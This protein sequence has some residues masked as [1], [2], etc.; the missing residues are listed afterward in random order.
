MFLASIDAGKTCGRQFNYATRIIGGE[1][2]D[3]IDEFPWSVSIQ[4]R[5][6]GQ[7]WQECGGSILTDRLVISAA[8]CANNGYVPYRAVFGCAN[9]TSEDCQV[10]YFSYEDWILHP[11][12]KTEDGVKKEIGDIALIKL[13]IKA[14]YSLET[15]KTV[16]SVCLPKRVRDYDGQEVT[17]IGYGLTHSPEDKDREEY[18]DVL[19][20]YTA[21]VI[22][23]SS[24][25]KS[26]VPPLDVNFP[27]EYHL[28][29]SRGSNNEGACNGDS[30]GPL[31]IR[32]RSGQMVVIGL[33]IDTAPD[34]VSGPILYTRVDYYLDWIIDIFRKGF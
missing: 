29:T 8:H 22:D 24:C 6:S 10:I 13:P 9:L 21:K 18:S 26:V 1:D 30:G 3:S 33:A 11:D 7:W 4:I 15:G 28:C 23:L 12:Y 27:P 14:N 17:A 16:G 20:K 2:V 32:S 19:Q 31:L 25:R 34:C 5:D